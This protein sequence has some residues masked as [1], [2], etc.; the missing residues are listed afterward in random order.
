MTSKTEVS[1]IKI[2]NVDPSKCKRWKFADRIEADFF[3]IEELAEDILKNGQI[4]PVLIRAVDDEKFKYEIIAGSRRWKACLLA[5]IPL[6]AILTDYND[7][8]AAIA[9]IKENEKTGLSNYSR[10]ISY[11]ILL[12]N[13]ILSQEQLASSLGVSRSKLQSLICFAKIPESVMDAIGN[14]ERISA[15]S[16]NSIYSLSK[17]GEDHI[18]ALIEIA[19]K[20]KLGLASYDIEEAVKNIVAGKQD[21]TDNDIRNS[22]GE[23]IARW[24]MGSLIIR[25]K[26]SADRKKLTKLV[27]YFLNN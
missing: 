19:E 20:I 7:T 8:Q 12:K 11:S 1:D 5:N 26:N 3:K 25:A 21:L 6:K 9:Q 22:K 24:R 10:G 14:P 18:N 13:K 4:N 16:A 23:V 15:R 2:L 17:K 27:E